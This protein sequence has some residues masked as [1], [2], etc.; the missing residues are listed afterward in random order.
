MLLSE[1]LGKEK[2]PVQPPVLE[3]QEANCDLVATEGWDHSVIIGHGLAP[4]GLEGR[5]LVVQGEWDL[6]EHEGNCILVP[7]PE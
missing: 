7:V 3:K 2:P 5:C 6:R 4:K 1:I